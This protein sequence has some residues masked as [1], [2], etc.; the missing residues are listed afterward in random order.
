M[1]SQGT[2]VFYRL[3]AN[4]RHDEGATSSSSE[5]LG[6]ENYSVNQLSDKKWSTTPELFTKIMKKEEWGWRAGCGCSARAIRV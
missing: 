6:M 2:F 5:I 1:I 4:R 3:L